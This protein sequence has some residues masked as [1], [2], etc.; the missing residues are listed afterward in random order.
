MT[1]SVLQLLVL[2]C[3]AYLVLTTLVQFAFLA[4]GGV[5]NAVRKLDDES[6]D[7]ETL[8]S[9]RF[10]IP[11]SVIV[12]A[13]NEERVI[14]STVRSFL[15]FDYPEFEVIVAND[16]STDGTLERL[17]E[18]FD[19]EP[20]EVFVRHVFPSALVRSIY[21][22]RTHP[23]LVV[24]DKENGGKADTWNAAL[25]VA[26][27]RYVCGVDADT[28]F[29][30]RALLKVMRVAV[31]DPARIVGVTSQITTAREPER[32]LALP[33]GRRRVD[34]GP[35]AVYQHL[36]F[37]RAFLNNRLAWSRFG[38]MLC[39]PGGFQIWRRDV[40]EELGGY[41]TSF[42]CEDIELTFRV[43]EH[44]RR[45]G[46]EYQ[47]PC[48][49][50]S[51][52]ITESPD[53]YAKLI[54]Q[55][56]RWQR[57]IS[58]TVVHYRH[59]WFNRRYGSVGFVGTPFYLLTEVVSPAIEVVALA[60]LAV[61]VVVGLFDPVTFVVVLAAIAFVNAALTA[62]AILLDDLQ[63][64]L[65]RKRD[66]ARILAFAPLELLLYRPIIFWARVKG[67]WGFLRGDKSWNRF[68]RNVRAP[69]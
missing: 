15:G 7:Y 44:F 63:S 2:L 54:S 26:R 4:I 6:T 58:E 28:V 68:E 52:G 24:I 43:H 46:R 9:S 38:F 66:L 41:S 40:L 55:R 39:S 36:D 62:G 34:G 50:D 16:G 48:L 49:P 14:E 67:S 47:L 45:E 21:R 5:E 53:T 13:Y 27:Y 17:R 30:P 59:M 35:L 11:V 8:S 42:T 56:E 33:S 10:T 32:V 12:A 25:N 69:A 61:A 64:R 31:R 18:A 65:Y 29:D 22:S 20:Y 57:V 60:T 51:V 23:N 37:L 19:L 3:L 1:G